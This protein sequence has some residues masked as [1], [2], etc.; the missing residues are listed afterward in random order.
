MVILAI[1]SSYFRLQGCLFVILFLLLL[2][3]TTLVQKK[4]KVRKMV[5]C[6]VGKG[7]SGKLEIMKRANR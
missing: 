7:V 4:R 3:N 5:N 1:I 6:E 2:D